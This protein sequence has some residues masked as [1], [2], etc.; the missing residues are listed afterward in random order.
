MAFGPN[1]AKLADSGGLAAEG[2]APRREG[3]FYN[4]GLTKI[5]DGTWLEV[6]VSDMTFGLGG[7]IRTSQGGDDAYNVVGCADEDIAPGSWGRVVISGVKY[8]AL[9]WDQFPV[10][11]NGCQVSNQVGR[12]ESSGAATGTS[13]IVGFTLAVA[14]TAGAHTVDV[15]IVNL[16]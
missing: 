6:D 11:G 9:A 1:V 4:P 15:Y 3:V 5:A 10:V 7:S 16:D 13:N 12:V 2:S 14:N 8:G